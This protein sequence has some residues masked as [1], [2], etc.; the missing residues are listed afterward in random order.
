MIPFVLLLCACKTWN[1]EEGSTGAS[2]VVRRE[3]AIKRAF[4]GGGR[5]KEAYTYYKQANK[6]KFLIDKMAE[7]D[8]RNE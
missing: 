1:R 5:S 8:G 3:L 4:P 7:M 2:L 6:K